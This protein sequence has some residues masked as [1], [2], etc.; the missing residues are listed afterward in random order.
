MRYTII[1]L[2]LIFAVVTLGNA[3]RCVAQNP[4]GKGTE[5]CKPHENRCMTIKTKTYIIKAC[6]TKSQ[7]TCFKGLCLPG[8]QITCCEKDMCNG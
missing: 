5:N 1:V 6:A 4:Q 3:L 7:C 8:E 2:L